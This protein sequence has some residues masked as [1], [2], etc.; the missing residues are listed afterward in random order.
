MGHLQAWPVVGEVPMDRVWFLFF[1][2]FIWIS[3]S[4]SFSCFLE[5]TTDE[6][7]YKLVKPG[8]GDLEQGLHLSTFCWLPPHLDDIL[9]ITR[10]S[11]ATTN[12]SWKIVW[13]GWKPEPRT[14]PLRLC[15]SLPEFLDQRCGG[16]T[17]FR[18]KFYQPF[19]SRPVIL[20][21]SHPNFHCSPAQ[22]ACALQFGHIFTFKK[23]PRGLSC[24]QQAL[25]LKTSLI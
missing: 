13:S 16:G 8:D 11:G 5:I 17:W 4:L 7:G 14:S 24:H 1:L 19:S 12:F 21:I 22:Q 9:I 10:L 25:L 18:L 20:G 23:C 3:S 2:F 6:A 15:A